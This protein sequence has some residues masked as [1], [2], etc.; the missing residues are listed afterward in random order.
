M[1]DPRYRLWGGVFTWKLWTCEPSSTVWE[2][3]S[4]WDCGCVTHVQG[5]GEVTLE[6]VDV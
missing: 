6:I 5:L 1:C 3:G 4:P 2:V